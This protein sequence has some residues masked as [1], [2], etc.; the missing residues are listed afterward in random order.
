MELTPRK[1]AV[2]KAIIKAYI[3][4]GEPIG[5]KNLIAY[6]EN[7]PSSATLRNEMSEL[8]QLGFLHQPHTSAGRVPTIG[9]Y[10]HYIDSLM[11]QY[12]LAESTKKFID[13][14]LE[15]L[16]CAPENIP[17]AATKVLSKLTGLPA[18]ASTIA[19]STP[20]LK[21]IE[22]LPIGKF[23]VMLLIITD[24][25][26]MRNR[27][28][29][30]SKGIDEQTQNSFFELVQQKIK[31]KYVSELSRAYMQSVIA[32]A[33][34]YA[35]KLM[36]LLTAIFETAAEIEQTDITISGENALY[37]IT[38]SEENARK[39]ITL[40][41]RRDPIISILKGING[42]VG[43]IFGADTV[44]GELKGNAVIAA[45]FSVGDKYKGYLGII[46]PNRMSYDEIIPATQYTAQKMTSIMTEAQKD[47]ED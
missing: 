21:R 11:P 35:L 5:S 26:R 20:K 41:N 12:R 1:Q 34:I 32:S 14:Q 15:N 37:N 33:G 29:R 28:F 36:P 31:G 24:D 46:G 45:K 19:Q 27:I 25:G 10:R 16:S 23:S 7:A 6:L 47:M 9:G 4:I 30:Q 43:T 38:S 2:L 39:I 3:E 22:L 40:I 42:N 13:E 44:Y 18:I 8:S 17:E